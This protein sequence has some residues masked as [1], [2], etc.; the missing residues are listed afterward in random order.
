MKATQKS[1]Q[2]F[3]VPGKI[4]MAGVS[5]DEK[6]FGYQLFKLLRDQ[7]YEVYP[8]HPLADQIGGIRCVH[9]VAEVPAEVCR[10]VVV[11]PKVQTAGI[12]KTAL[13]RGFDHIWIQQFSESPGVEAMVKDKA[14][15]VVLKECL[16]MHLQPVKGIHK[17]HRAIRS[18]FGGMPK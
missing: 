3:L 10:L 9:S 11:T 2:P 4:A 5:R 14:V 13:E 15:N 6:K 8:V 1:I 17:F 16:F 18:L 7:G 12:V